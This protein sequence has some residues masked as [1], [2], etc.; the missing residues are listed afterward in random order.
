MKRFTTNANMPAP[1]KPALGN[2][3]EGYFSIFERGLV[4][5][6]KHMSEQH[7][8]RYLA[9]FDFHMGNRERL[10]ANDTMRADLALKG[11]AGKRLM[12][13]IPD[14]SKR[15]SIPGGAQAA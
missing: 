15:P 4:G 6:Y 5:T 14:G 12:Y 9:E 1:T 10:G 2:T 7:L 3:A 11:V 13:R 8:H